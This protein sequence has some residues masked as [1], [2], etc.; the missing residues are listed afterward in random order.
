MTQSFVRIYT[1]QLRWRL[2]DEPLSDNPQQALELDTHLLK[3]VANG[4]RAATCRIWETKQ[5]LVVTRK[6]TR[7]PR[8]ETAARTLNKMGWPVI[9]RNSGGTTVPLHPG[10]LNLSLIF[11]QHNLDAYS[12]DDIYMALCEPIKQ[13]LNTIGINTEY[14]ETPGSYCDG[15]FNLNVDGLKI[16]GTAQKIMVSPPNPKEIKQAILAQAMLM[17]EADAAQ[18]TKWVNTFYAEAGNERQFNPDVSTSVSECLG[19]TALDG[20]LT[21]MIRERLNSCIEKLIIPESRNNINAINT[22]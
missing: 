1:D 14:G 21:K 19:E 4:K 2:I 6:E 17:V 13:A 8:Y 22:R 3:E 11:P 7:F 15:R 9:V 20:Q 16:T 18:G 12:L 5:C 10:I